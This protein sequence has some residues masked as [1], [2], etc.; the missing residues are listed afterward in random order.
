MLALKIVH[1]TINQSI[2]QCLTSAVSM[3][4][5]HNTNMQQKSF[6]STHPQIFKNGCIWHRK[7]TS[8]GTKRNINSNGRQDENT[9]QHLCRRCTVCQLQIHY[10]H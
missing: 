7:P 5:L 4:A 2:N 9:Y 8:V 1:Q 3:A 10:K 6:Y